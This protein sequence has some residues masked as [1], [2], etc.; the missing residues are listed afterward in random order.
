[1][2]QK[3]QRMLTHKFAARDLTQAI[4]PKEIEPALTQRCETSCV[5]H[6]PN[7]FEHS[8]PK[9]LLRLYAQEEWLALLETAMLSDTLDSHPPYTCPPS[10][11]LR[12]PLA[13]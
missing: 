5:G 6:P 13:R 11:E 1:M 7:S 10:L 2:R 9:I 4:Q 3:M 8:K 12:E